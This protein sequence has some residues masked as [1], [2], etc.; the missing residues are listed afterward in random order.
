M[1]NAFDRTAPDGGVKTT[2]RLEEGR[3]MFEWQFFFAEE[4]GDG[5][6]YVRLWDERREMALECVGLA[7]EDEPLRAIL[8]QPHL[9]QGSRD[10]YL[11]TLEAVLTDRKG[12]CLDRMTRPLPLRSEEWRASRGFLLNGA[13]FALRTV[14]YEHPTRVSCAKAQKVVMED[15]QRLLSLGANSVYMEQGEGLTQPFLQLCDR[16]GIIVLTELSYLRS[17]DDSAG[18]EPLPVLWGRKGG[19]IAG[20]GGLSSEYYRLRAAWSREPFVYIAPESIKRQE[21][22]NFSVTVFSS[23]RRVALYSD[24]VLF[25]FKNGQGEFIFREVP[26]KGPCVML[27][28]EGEGCSEAF[29]CHK[30][31]TKKTTKDS[32][33]AL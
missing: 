13:P 9:W 6:V 21:N 31:F 20:D 15:M 1:R 19:M 17:A 14:A 22:G 8:R 23:C 25:E 30:L 3:A 7:A 11:Y 16:L 18:T 5:L 32:A 33:A 26:A 12:A 27:T 4:P 28:A 2:I 24:G 10:P 29:S